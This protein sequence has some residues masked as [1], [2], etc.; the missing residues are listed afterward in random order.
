MPRLD[1]IQVGQ[2]VRIVAIEGTDA[3]VQR[4]MEMALLPGEEIELVRRAPLGDPLEIRLTD[5]LSQH[6]P[7]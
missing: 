3:L 4:L 2:H 5:V 6:P 7:Q 1:E